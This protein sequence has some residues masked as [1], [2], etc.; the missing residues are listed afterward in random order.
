MYKTLE[1]IIR[2]VG[3]GKIVSEG[4]NRT[5][6]SKIRDMR[7]AKIDTAGNKPAQNRN[8]LE[9]DQGDQVPVGSYMTK[10]FE[11]S[12]PA[13]VFF[14]KHVP[15]DS[16]PNSVEQMANYT[17]KAFDIFKTAIASQS[18]TSKDLED[19]NDHIRKIYD[20][21][22]NLNVL[23]KVKPFIEKELNNVHK[24]K[25]D[26]NPTN[27]VSPDKVDAEKALRLTNKPT[28]PHEIP[29]D[30]DTDN[31]QM[32][33][34]RRQ[35][36]ERKLKIIDD[37][38]HH[39]LMEAAGKYSTDQI[40]DLVGKME[41]DPSTKTSIALSIGNAMIRASQREDTRA[42]SLLI[43]ALQLLEMSDGNETLMGV[44]RRLLS[45]AITTKN[46]KEK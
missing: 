31:Q 27:Q 9:F 20:L 24:F 44:A 18:I 6:E 29:R 13:Q 26:S 32:F 36:A 45:T 16:D 42:L 11:L 19:A 14:L 34:N 35:K 8:Q 5:L 3:L 23:D 40:S 21:A 17:D 38:Y 1:N 10:N 15:K 30:F 4:D 41:S 12:K 2:Q 37:E 22:T 39:E 43:G 33:I 28:D 7:E 46:K 25:R